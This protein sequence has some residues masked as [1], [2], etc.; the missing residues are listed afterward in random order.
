MV[1]E[2]ASTSRGKT[3]KSNE[4]NVNY[5]VLKLSRENIKLVD[6]GRLFEEFLDNGLKDVNMV[7]IDLEWKPSF[8]NHTWQSKLE[9]RETKTYIL[10]I[11]MFI[12][13]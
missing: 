1:N 2:G 7:G 6:D 13:C 11:N 3:W 9:Y 10:H 12:F 4:D 5:H 8:G